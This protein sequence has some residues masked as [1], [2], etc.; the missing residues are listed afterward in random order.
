MAEIVGIDVSKRK[1]DCALLLKEKFKTKV[2]ENT[3]QGYR[4]LG[5]WLKHQGVERAQ[6]CME[7]TGVYYEALALHLHEAGQV[8]SVVNPARIKGF[9]QSV[10]ARTKTDRVDARL[11]ARFCAAHQPATWQPQAPRLR[12]LQALVAR[13]EALN[14]MLTQETN[15]LAIAPALTRGSIEK[16]VEVL[17]QEIA[18]LKRQIRKHIDHHPDLRSKHDLP[19]SIPGIGA[20]TIAQILACGGVPRT[21]RTRGS[22]R[23]SWGSRRDSTSRA[24]QRA[25]ARGSRRPATRGCARP[26]SCRRWWPFALTRPSKH[27]PR[28]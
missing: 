22:S 21:S 2:F 18:A 6:V 13:V 8:V 25:G 9:A 28:V 20:A 1:F 4:E 16:I 24:V 17:A 7:A 11:I 10:L 5:D 26:S 23:P 15:R 12:E 3:E 27:S 19:Q 14:H